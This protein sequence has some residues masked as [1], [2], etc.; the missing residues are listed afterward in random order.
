[1]PFVA[2]Y[3]STQGLIVVILLL[4]LI[5]L[6]VM[7]KQ[8]FKKRKKLASFAIIKAA[9]QLS[10]KQMSY[11]MPK[12]LSIISIQL[13][14]LVMLYSLQR[15]KL[16]ASL[17]PSPLLLLRGA[18][19]IQCLVLAL[20]YKLYLTIVMPLMCTPL[21]CCTRCLIAARLGCLRRLCQII[22]NNF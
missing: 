10:V 8:F 9:A 4:D 7:L 18:R 15:E 19:R 17:A 11:Q 2:N 3:Y 20:L 13:F 12:N 21:A 5:T 22:A 6:T 16:I 1:M 14:S